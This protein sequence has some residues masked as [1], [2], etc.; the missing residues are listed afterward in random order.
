MRAISRGALST[1]SVAGMVLML[2]APAQAT[3]QEADSG[4]NRDFWVSVDVHTITNK[5]HD[6][7]RDTARAPDT[8]VVDYHICPYGEAQQV[9]NLTITVDAPGTA[10]DRTFTQQE[11]LDS[12]AC[13]GGFWAQRL[14]KRDFGAGAYTVTVSGNNGRDDATVSGSVLITD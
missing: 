10:M 12:A 5:D 1:A 7:N 2:A 8:L 9:V 13:G 11:V 14:K 6:N 4:P 3:G